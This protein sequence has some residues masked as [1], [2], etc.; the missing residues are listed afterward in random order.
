VRRGDRVEITGLLRDPMQPGN[1]GQFDYA[2]YLADRGVSKLVFVPDAGLV[3]PLASGG[4]GPLRF[5][6]SLRNRMADALYASLPPRDA[7]LLAAL[8]L[9][10]AGGLQP[11]SREAFTRAGT[12]HLLAVSGLHLML[13]VAGLYLFLRCVRL[14][15]KGA[16]VVLIAFVWFF[17]ALTGARTS[18]LRAA[19]MTTVYL[20]ATLLGRERDSL[21]ALAFSALVLLWMRPTDLFAPGFQ[22]SFAAVLGILLLA[23][24]RGRCRTCPAPPARS[25][26]STPG[27]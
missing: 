21:N 10:D 24:P 12:V 5:L 19:W 2:A 16:A 4:P 1:P 7:A 22:L 23:R 15:G 9:G 17:V 27:R 8:L 13:V 3:R 20:G 18:V 25:R 26:R 14:R 11:A 6:E